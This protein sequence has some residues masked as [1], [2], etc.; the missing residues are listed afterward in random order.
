MKFTRGLVLLAAMISP[1]AAA[2]ADTIPKQTLNVDEK[3]S[4]AHKL[5]AVVGNSNAA[6]LDVSRGK[7]LVQAPV[8]DTNNDSSRVISFGSG[9]EKWEYKHIGKNASD[10]GE[11]TAAVTVDEPQTI[12]LLLFGL[13]VLG[14]I[15]WRRN[16]WNAAI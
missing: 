15:V 10:A 4:S 3:A 5:T 11:G 13:A 14:V 12:T 6:L 2:F 16:I 7:N 1:L 9:Q 8:G